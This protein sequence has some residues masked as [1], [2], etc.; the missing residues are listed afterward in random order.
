MYLLSTS[1]WSLVGGGGG[2]NAGELWSEM[3]ENKE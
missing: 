1:E 2:H 3:Q